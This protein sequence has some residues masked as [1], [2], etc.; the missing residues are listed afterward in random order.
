MKK[1]AN[2]FKRRRGNSFSKT[3]AAGKTR[4]RIA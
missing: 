1:I 4:K 2:N 3:L